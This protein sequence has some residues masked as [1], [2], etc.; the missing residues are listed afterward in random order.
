MTEFAILYDKDSGG[1]KAKLIGTSQIADLAITSAKIGA[2]AVGTPHIAAN[3]IVSGKV[4]SGG[5]APLTSGKFWAGFTGNIPREENKPTKYTDD[6]AQ[7]TVKANVE[8][9]D[10]K[11]PTKA[12]AMNSQ[13]ITGLLAPAAA[14]DALRKGTRITTTE[15][16]SMTD[17]KI[18]KGTGNNV[19]EVDMPTGGAPTTTGTY[20]G[21]ETVNRAIPHGLGV[22]PKLVLILPTSNALYVI[23]QMAWIIAVR[24]SVLA[25]TTPDATNFYVGNAASYDF[26]AQEVREYRWV[27]IG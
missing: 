2:L 15:L 17:E 21:D 27:A 26:S 6:E 9:G 22:T 16:P 14:G 20:T 12:L 10:L 7:I 1:I 13:K 19:E 8:V 3:A 11:A 4:A 18:W 25:V 23:M 24:Q 5:L